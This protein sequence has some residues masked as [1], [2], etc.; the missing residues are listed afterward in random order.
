MFKEAHRW[1][2]FVSLHPCLF[3]GGAA[4][5]HWL[6]WRRTSKEK[7]D[8][9]RPHKLGN[10]RILPTNSAVGE[11]VIICK[12]LERDRVIY[13]W[14]SNIKIVPSP[15]WLYR[16]T[17]LPSKRNA[18]DVDTLGNHSHLR[19]EH[20]GCFS[21]SFWLLHVLAHQLMR[22]KLS[23]RLISK[24]MINDTELQQDLEV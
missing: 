19:N 7:K 24:V 4:V 8:G 1:Q 9:K 20:L 16:F 10:Q 12:H 15:W 17:Q 14:K 6:L 13:V 21:T 5:S 3:P 22:W 23:E 18:A 2:W 11:S